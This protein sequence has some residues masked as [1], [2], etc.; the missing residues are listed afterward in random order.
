M[1]ARLHSVVHKI[2]ILGSKKKCWEKNS[3]RYV[4]HDTVVVNRD[5]KIIYREENEQE[6][7]KE[8]YAL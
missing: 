7:E 1:S 2:T 3:Q 8:D 4:S 6:Q 5:R